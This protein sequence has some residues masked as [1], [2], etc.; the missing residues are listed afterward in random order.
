MYKLNNTD[1]TT[2][3]ILAEVM[4]LISHFLEEKTKESALFSGECYWYPDDRDNHVKII[5]YSFSELNPEITDE[6]QIKIKRRGCVASYFFLQPKYYHGL[7][8]GIIDMLKQV[9]E[10]RHIK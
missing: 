5:K 10:N 6:I 8:K 4:Y 2:S 9:K 1:Q 3:E 7:E